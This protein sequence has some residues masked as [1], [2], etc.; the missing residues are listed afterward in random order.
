MAETFIFTGTLVVTVFV[1]IMG[2]GFQCAVQLDHV[3][4]TFKRE[5]ILEVL[6]GIIFSSFI[7]SKVSP[8]NHSMRL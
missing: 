1:Q 4:I 3:C 7:T 6:L 2:R 8:C 5:I